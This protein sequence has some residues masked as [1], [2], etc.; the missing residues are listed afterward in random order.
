[1]EFPDIGKLPDASTKDFPTS[2]HQRH[3]SIATLSPKYHLVVL[4][5]LG[6]LSEE[7]VYTLNHIDMI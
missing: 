3:G 5:Y 6:A 2:W 1:M 7:L 4:K